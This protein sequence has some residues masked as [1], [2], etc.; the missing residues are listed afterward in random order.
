M[1]EMIAEALA[2]RERERRRSKPMKKRRRRLEGL[3]QAQAWALKH[4]NANMPAEDN[5]LFDRPSFQVRFEGDK[6]FVDPQLHGMPFGFEVE[7]TFS[8]SP[9]G[10]VWI[11]G[12][13]P[14]TGSRL[15]LLWIEGIFYEGD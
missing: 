12:V 13:N 6:M 1:K 9:V 10:S 11:G 14:T 2:R 8:E 5:T 7:Y 4:F 15:P 3:A